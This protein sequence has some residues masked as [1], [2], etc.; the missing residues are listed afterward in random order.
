MQL[1]E[2]LTRAYNAQVKLEFES[3][4]VYLQMGADLELRSLP[5]FSRWMRLQAAEEH[6]HAMKFIDFV[7]S[8]GGRLEL[9]ALEKPA[10]TPGTVVEVFEAALRHEQRV[11]KAIHDLYAQALEERDFASLPL[12]QWFVNEQTEEEATV[13]QIL[14]RLRMVGEDRTGLLFLDRELGQR[15]AGGGGAAGDGGEAAEA[16]G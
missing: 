9:Q 10:P 5:G 6:G 13:S 7:L 12:L 4:F 14:E 11:T 16:A 3:S 8:R 1:S 15:Q 2:P